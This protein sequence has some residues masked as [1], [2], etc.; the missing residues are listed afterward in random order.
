MALGNGLHISA[1]AGRAMLEYKQLAYLF[2]AETQA[3][4]VLD[5]RQAFQCLGPI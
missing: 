5:E 1:G 4:G 2:K 3:P